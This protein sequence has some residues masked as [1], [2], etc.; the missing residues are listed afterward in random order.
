MLLNANF[1]MALTGQNISLSLLAP[2]FPWDADLQSIDRPE[3][4]PAGSHKTWDRVDGETTFRYVLAEVAH[5]EAL[6]F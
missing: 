5:V 2:N 3:F 1:K 4:M 6:R